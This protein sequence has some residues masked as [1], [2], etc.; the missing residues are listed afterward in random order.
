MIWAFGWR[1]LPSRLTTQRSGSSCVLRL[2]SPERVSEKKPSGEHDE[3][4]K[5]VLKLPYQAGENPPMG[6]SLLMEKSTS[7]QGLSLMKTSSG[8]MKTARNGAK[9]KLSGSFLPN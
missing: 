3:G 9:Q 4:R 8:S 1:V 2:R 5:T 7:G 6:I